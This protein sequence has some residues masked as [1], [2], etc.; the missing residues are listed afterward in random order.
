M[1][2]IVGADNREYGPVTQE[3]VLQWIAQGRANSQTI[4]RAEDGGAWKPLGTFDEF[5]AALNISATTPPPLSGTTVGGYATIPPTPGGKKSNAAAITGLVCGIL[6]ICCCPPTGLIAIIC[7]Y[8]ALDQI[9][10]NPMAY[11]TDTSLPKIAIGLGIAGL[12]LF[13]LGLIFNTALGAFASKFA[14]F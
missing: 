13:V 2:K 14:N 6:G 5:K 8:I 3:E 10:K 1:Y 12:V 11:T 4:A 9:R 7:G